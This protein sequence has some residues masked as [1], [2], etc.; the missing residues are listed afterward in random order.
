MKRKIIILLILLL[1]FTGCTQAATSY[2]TVS[3]E[4]VL[5][6]ADNPLPDN[7]ETQLVKLDNGVCV[8]SRV[9]P[10]L[11]AMFDAMR[12]DDI[13]PV[14]GEGYRTHEA[15]EKIM[16]NKVNAFLD[17]GYSRKDAK[18]LAKDWV[19]EPGRSE[20]EL[21]IALD[22]NADKSRSGNEEVYQWLA[23][24]AY[25]YG[26]ILRYPEGAEEITGIDYEPWHYRY[27]GKEAAKEI[28]SQGVTLEEYLS[29]NS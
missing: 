14:A 27:V 6:N 7:W 25:K 11:Q 10:D 28:Y 4:L 18:K 19:A 24:H 29:E 23:D 13:Y 2:N 17:E 20:H 3:W 15:Q 8:D 9:Y 22:I 12:S 1:T 16:E 26:F 5:V 21:G